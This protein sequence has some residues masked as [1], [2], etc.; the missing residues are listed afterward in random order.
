M[1]ELRRESQPLEP[2]Q[3]V[4]PDPPPPPVMGIGWKLWWIGLEPHFVASGWTTNRANAILAVR[5]AVRNRLT[6][7]G[8]ILYLGGPDDDP[9]PGD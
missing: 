2:T 1:V 3:L 8:E 6:R 4:I 9:I 5:Q 7:D